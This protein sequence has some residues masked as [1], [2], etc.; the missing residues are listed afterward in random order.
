MSNIIAAAILK[1]C[2]DG[3]QFCE[4]LND[5]TRLQFAIKSSVFSLSKLYCG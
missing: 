4:T 3:S 1:K 5:N 2:N